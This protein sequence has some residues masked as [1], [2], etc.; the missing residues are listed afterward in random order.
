MKLLIITQKV[1][2]DDPILGFFHRWIIEFAK[3][4]EQLTVICLEEGVHELPQ[5]V[6]VLS[7]GK[8]QGVGRFGRVLRLYKYVWQYRHEYTHV[9][10]HMNQ[11]YVLVCGVLWRL[12]RKRICLWYAHGTVSISLR[13]ALMLVH[14]VCTS[15]PKGFR[16]KSKKVQVVGQGIDT[17]LFKPDVSL[18]AKFPVI[19]T[20]GRIAR[21]KHLSM[22]LDALA[23][24][25]DVHVWVV[26]EAVTSEDL[27]YKKQCYE[28]AHKLGVTDKVT[29]YGAKTY[30][31]LVPLYQQAHVVVNMSTTG[32][33]D[34]VILEAIACGVPVISSN[35]AAAG[36]VGVQ[37]IDGTVTALVHTLQSKQFNP[38]DQAVV[39][40]V[41]RQHG[42]SRLI[43]VILKTIV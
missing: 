34:K 25:H 29:W 32:S 17:D 1:N 24:V 10:V 38:L 11:V 39:A 6:C 21:V 15:T 5:N 28:L 22:L 20:V 16:I 12:L 33:L 42:L 3:H 8:E 18:R 4:V 26:G 9:F 2:K 43:Q 36:I 37:Y 40:S 35:E 19:L 14:T 23:H 7:L 30:T 41:A 27:L 31:E 13:F